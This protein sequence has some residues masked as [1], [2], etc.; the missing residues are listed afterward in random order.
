MGYEKNMIFFLIKKKKKKKKRLKKS[1]KS[2][3]GPRSLTSF[4]RTCVWKLDA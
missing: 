2:H 3:Q 4:A 1:E